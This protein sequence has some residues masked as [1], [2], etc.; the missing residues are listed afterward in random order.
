MARPVPDRPKNIE[1]GSRVMDGVGWIRGPLANSFTFREGSRTYLLDAG[2]PDAAQ[3]V[4]EAFRRADVPLAQLSDILLTHQHPD[5]VGGAA[6]LRWV[7][8]AK[9]ACHLLDAPAVEGRGPLLAPFLVRVLFRRHPVQVDRILRDGDTVGPFTV[10]STPGHTIG[11]VSFYHPERKLLFCGDAALTSR[12]GVQL[13]AGFSN[14]D[15]DSSVRSLEKLAA[16]EV[17][18]LFPGHGRPIVANAGAVLKE[19]AQRLTKVK[20]RKWWTLVG[21]EGNPETHPHLEPPANAA[22]R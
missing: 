6:Y 3:P 22:A 9:V 16:L 15:H 10:V 11:S 21:P 5:H 8:R 4:R 2:F 19:A 20:E 13:A 18:A 14:F 12:Q 17:A 1:I 7:S